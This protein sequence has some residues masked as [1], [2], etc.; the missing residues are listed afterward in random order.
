MPKFSY[1]FLYNLFLCGNL[2]TFGFFF[3][4]NEFSYNVKFGILGLFTYQNFV[5][6]FYVSVLLG[7]YLI[8]FNILI[9]QIFNDVII[10]VAACFELVI[11]ALYWHVLSL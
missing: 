1:L 4:G 3:G 5:S 8:L 2:V 10:N 6:V 11:S 9:A 7:F